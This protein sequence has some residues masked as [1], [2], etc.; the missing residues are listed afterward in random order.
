MAVYGPSMINSDKGG[1]ELGA[2]LIQI[3]DRVDSYLE[4]IALLEDGEQPISA[5][6]E[7]LRVLCERYPRESATAL[8]KAQVEKW[9]EE[10]VPW[11]EKK[12]ATLPK[13][14]RDK[15]VEASTSDLE[16]LASLA[17]F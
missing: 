14:Y 12:K 13:E 3:C 5:D 15:I 9:K 2:I 17:V 11:L 6:L 1:V 8:A 4:K 7:I 10:F 16:A